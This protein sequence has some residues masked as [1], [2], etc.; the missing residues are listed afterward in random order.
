MRSQDL[1]LLVLDLLALEGSQAAQLHI[2]DGLGLEL[3][4]VEALHQA[5]AWRHRRPATGGW[6]G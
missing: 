4:Q 3:A 6:S 5:L 1:A 2:Q